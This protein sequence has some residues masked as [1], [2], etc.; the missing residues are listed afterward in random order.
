MLG[1]VTEADSVLGF[2]KQRLVVLIR[3]GTERVCDLLGSRLL[4]LRKK[5]MIRDGVEQM[6]IGR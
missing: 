1:R 4:A 5:D 3:V 6:S 2:V